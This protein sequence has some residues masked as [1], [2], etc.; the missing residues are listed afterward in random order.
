MKQPVPDRDLSP[1]NLE[2]ILDVLEETGGPL[3][4][5]QIQLKLGQD[6]GLYLP[7]GDIRAHLVWG[8]VQ[9]NATSTS[10]Q[11]VCISEGRG[12]WISVAREVR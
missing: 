9:P 12:L 8:A 1:D 3:T 11:P 6:R 2:T 7:R 4:V 10:V 5:G